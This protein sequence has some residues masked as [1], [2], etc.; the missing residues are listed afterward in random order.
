[1]VKAVFG[2][3]VYSS[4]GKHIS[5]EHFQKK[6]IKLIAIWNIIIQM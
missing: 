4:E 5:Y 3:G 6:Q 1:M 2:C